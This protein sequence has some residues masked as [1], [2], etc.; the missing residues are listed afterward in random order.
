MYL[1]EAMRVGVIV[2]SAALPRVPAQD[3]QVVL[4]ITS[5]NKVPDVPKRERER[6]MDESNG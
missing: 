5:V 4:A 2:D 1:H 6:E 3:Y